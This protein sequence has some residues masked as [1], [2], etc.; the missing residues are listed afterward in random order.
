MTNR[1]GN[2]GWNKMK[3]EVN[4]N[5]E[6][7]WTIAQNSNDR[8]STQKKNQCETGHSE[9]ELQLFMGQLPLVIA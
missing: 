8:L 4:L 3:S 6:P 9:K 2:K 7:I 1:L 5:L